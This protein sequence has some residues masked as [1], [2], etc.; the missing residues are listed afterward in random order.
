MNKSQEFLNNLEEQKVII[1]EPVLSN[2]Q[3]ECVMGHISKLHEEYKALYSSI[4]GFSH[5][6]L[7]HKKRKIH[8]MLDRVVENQKALDHFNRHFK[9]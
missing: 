3:C 8:R 5:G 6:A 2:E 4:V 9:K 1:D 7:P